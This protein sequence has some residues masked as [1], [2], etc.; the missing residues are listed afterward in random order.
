M[1]YSPESPPILNIICMGFHGWD[2]TIGRPAI[3]T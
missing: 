2:I 3:V 1:K